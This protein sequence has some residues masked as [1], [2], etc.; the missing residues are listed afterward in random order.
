MAY[1]HYEAVN[2]EGAKITGNIDADTSG[3]A[4]SILREKELFVLKVHGHNELTKHA[5]QEN[6]RAGLPAK[7]NSNTSN[8]GLSRDIQLFRP[9]DKQWAQVYRQLALMIRSGITLVEALEMAAR[10]AMHP[11]IQQVLF[12]VLEHVENG[13]P[14]A[15]AMQRHDTYF[16][17]S[18]IQ[19]IRCGEHSGDMVQVLGDIVGM[20]AYRAEQNKKIRSAMFIPKAVSIAVVVLFFI[21]S[22][23]LA[24]QFRSVLGDDL[25]NMPWITTSLFSFTDFFRQYWPFIFIL[26][27]SLWFGLRHWYKTDR[28]R[29]LVD[30]ILIRL[31]MLGSV[32]VDAEM[33]RA[34]HTLNLLLR[35]GL[36]LIDALRSIA[37]VSSNQHFIE[38]YGKGCERLLAGDAFAD[39]LVD[40]RVPEL[41]PHLVA[42]GERTGSLEEVTA[43]LGGY[44]RQE[45]E[46]RVKT[47]IDR[48]PVVM[49]IVIGSLV[50][51][52]YGGVM[53]GLAS[54]RF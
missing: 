47:L 22:Y 8:K 52:V 23:K 10:R 50:A 6:Q 21:I 1:F 16:G 19:L 40:Q 9:T 31:P 48:L 4:A 2:R 41:A 15:E 38:L 12:D 44:F 54:T 43:E 24:P 51:W 42:V 17:N 20:I 28:G 53:L 46:D 13:E 45:L 3:Q 27:A 34:F 25:Q 14:L 49:T 7:R 32:M 26:C 30:R 39:C 29:T 35:S 37:Q 5:G 33:N 18:T 36:P 11:R